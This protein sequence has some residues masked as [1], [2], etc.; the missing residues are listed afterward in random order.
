MYQSQAVFKPVKHSHVTKYFYALL[1]KLRRYNRQLILTGFFISHT[2]TH[3]HIANSV[4]V[5]C[6]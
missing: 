3:L 6:R 1:W 2:H 4:S 5:C